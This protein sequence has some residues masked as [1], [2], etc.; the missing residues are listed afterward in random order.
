MKTHSKSALGN[1]AD[2][3]D[4][5][6]VDPG[7]PTRNKLRVTCNLTRTLWTLLLAILLSAGYFGYNV[8][9][10]NY[11]RAKDPHR[12]LYQDL[13]V[14]YGPEDV[15]HPLVDADQTF[16][17]VA[18][19]WL[20]TDPREPAPNVTKDGTPVWHDPSALV[21]TAIF[22]ETVFR[23]LQLRDKNVKAAVKFQV[24]T[25]IL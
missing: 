17:I 1:S 21:E 15:V 24:P 11:I 19:V 6:V 25:E 4:S 10:K 8:V 2:V 16:D 20:R 12:A 9:Q 23:G 7:P 14:T 5:L 18:T 13:R 3:D 22:T